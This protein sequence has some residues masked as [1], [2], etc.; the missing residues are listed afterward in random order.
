[1]T[2]FVACTGTCGTITG[3]NR[4][5]KENNTGVKVVAAIPEVGHDIS[6]ARSREQLVH[7]KHFHEE[8]YDI[9]V[10]VPNIEA[11]KATDHLIR[12]EC[13]QAGPTSGCNLAGAIRGVPDE[14]DNVIVFLCCD[15]ITKYTANMQ[16]H[17]PELFP[18]AEPVPAAKTVDSKTE[19]KPATD[20]MKQFLLQ[21]YM[22]P[23]QPEVLDHAHLKSFYDKYKGRFTVV[24]VRPREG[25]ENVC[26]VPNSIHIP[27]DELERAF[28]TNDETILSKLP[29][30]KSTK[31]VCVAH[32]GIAS[33]SGLIVLKRLG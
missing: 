1:M 26:R 31:I 30:D 2:H 28:E 7:T 22:D 27:L 33:A 25:Y 5:F 14:E 18:T 20:P 17:L 16:K 29:K 21:L 3:I 10:D 12:K 24:D 8:E 4:W 19:S 9:V 32:R 11:Y 13:L 6:G 15:M 23:K